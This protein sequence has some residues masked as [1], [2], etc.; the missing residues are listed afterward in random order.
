M[1]LA[2]LLPF[3]VQINGMFL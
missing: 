1:G 3:H 2:L